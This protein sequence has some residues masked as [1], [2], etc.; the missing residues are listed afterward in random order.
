VFELVELRTHML[1]DAIQTLALRECM[2]RHREYYQPLLDEEEAEME[3]A[4]AAAEQS[5]ETRQE[6]TSLSSI[7]EEGDDD[8][9]PSKGKS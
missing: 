4:R 3:A 7:P 8:Y 9:G 2:L 1:L 6:G 5:P